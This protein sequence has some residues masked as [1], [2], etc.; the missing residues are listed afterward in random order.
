MAFKM[1]NPSM[2]K[3][4]RAAG[5]N[6]AAMKM[7]MEEKAAAKMRAE[8]AM[9]MKK[10]P[11]EKEL[12]GKQHNLPPELKAKIE[13][14]PSK[15]KK[16]AMK[17]KKSAVKKRDIPSATELDRLE[18]EGINI[19]KANPESTKQPET[20]SQGKTKMYLAEGVDGNMTKLVDSEGNHYINTKSGHD[21]VD[22]K[23][24]SKRSSKQ[25]TMDN[26]SKVASKT[27]RGKHDPETGKLK[28]RKT[29]DEKAPT[30]MKKSAMKKKSHEDRMAAIE[31]R[32]QKKIDRITGKAKEDRKAKRAQNKITRAGERGQ[33]KDDRKR[34]ADARKSS[35]DAAK[36]A[37]ATRKI[38]RK[39]T[40]L[41]GKE[42]RAI[43]R[44]D[45]KIAK[46]QTKKQ[47]AMDKNYKKMKKLVG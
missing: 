6:R 29:G 43:A 21:I 47:R 32:G 26:L 20:D 36:A 1:K 19:V 38:D 8:S 7:K 4:V 11:M 35:R 13:A 9:K 17:M 22:E 27:V 16:S 14:A 28:N 46:Q 41:Q 39:S 5:D 18:S 24:P 23:D 15:M 44:A 12:V 45:K 31:K 3:M 37:R 25:K 40:K 33:A 30:T 34:L 10:S 2:A 42:D